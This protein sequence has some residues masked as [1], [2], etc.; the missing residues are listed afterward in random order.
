MALPTMPSN[1]C[2][3]TIQK[4]H[5][6]ILLEMK[7]VKNVSVLNDYRSR[8]YTLYSCVVRVAGLLQTIE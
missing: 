2:S 8:M 7:S 5:A 6:L 1:S 3:V 4:L